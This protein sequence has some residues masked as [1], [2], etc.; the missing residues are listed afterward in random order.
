MSIVWSNFVYWKCLVKPHRYVNN[1]SKECF[2]SQVSGDAKNVISQR[3]ST[4]NPPPHFLPEYESQWWHSRQ[5]VG[6]GLGRAGFKF[7][8]GHGNLVVNHSLN[9]STEKLY[10]GCHKLETTGRQITKTSPCLYSRLYYLLCVLSSHVLFLWQTECIG[11]TISIRT[12]VSTL[13]H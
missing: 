4:L 5:N 7:L 1:Q 9:I 11:G 6:L 2:F 12:R 3:L 8:C 13:R 10:Q